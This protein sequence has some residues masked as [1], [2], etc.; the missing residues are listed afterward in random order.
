MSSTYSILNAIKKQTEIFL[1]EITA[2]NHI[3]NETANNLIY[4]NTSLLDLIDK[5]TKFKIILSI[6]DNLLN[7]ILEKLLDDIDD[8]EKDDVLKDLI[9]EVIN[10]IVGLSIQDFPVKYKN[11]SLSTPY[12]LSNDESI[13]LINDYEFT[14]FKTITVDG[15][16]ICYIIE[17]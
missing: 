16:L 2:V 10:I 6:D 13:N 12:K 3:E 17:S 1:E 14:S 5:N 8:S 7:K 9:D 4:K 15:D 11:L